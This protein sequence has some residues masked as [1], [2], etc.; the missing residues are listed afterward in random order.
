[1]K[2]SAAFLLTACLLLALLPARAT[3]A[4]AN[5]QW[6]D[7]AAGAYRSAAV[8]TVGL[9]VDGRPL[10]SDMPAILWGGRTLVPVRAL[11][12]ALGAEVLWREDSRQAVLRTARTTVT[13]TLGSATAQVNGKTV[14]LPD[15]VPA[16][17]VCTDSAVRTM[18]PLRFVAEQLRAAVDWDGAVPAARVTRGGAPV[19]DFTPPKDPGRYTVAIDPGHGG[20]QSGA[21]YEGVMEK[22]INLAVARLLRDRLE[23]LGYRVVMTMDADRTL[24]LYER[25]AIANANRA[26]IF[27]SL[28]S[29]A[30]DTSSTFQGIFTYHYPGSG[31]GAALA[32]AIQTP[33]CQVTGAIDRGILAE[34]F[35]V[36]RET[37]MPAALVEMGFMSTHAELMR[38]IDPDYQRKLAWGV[39]EGAV[40]YLNALT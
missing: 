36:V 32:Q 37:D 2:R 34:N 39:A 18:A 16:V 33:V 3:P 8:R 20:T 5:I 29:N 40:R 15:G 17:L 25:C 7:E 19:Y 21:A 10:V 14:P 27:I 35:V 13:L 28:H 30:S 26:D 24:G 9:T 31:R 22:S 23:S 11:G 1:M 4:A 38:L 6:Y 12:E